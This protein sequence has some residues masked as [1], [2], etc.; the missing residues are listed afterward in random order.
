MHFVSTKVSELE[1]Y[2][3]SCQFRLKKNFYKSGNLAPWVGKK[4]SLILLHFLFFFF[5]NLEPVALHF[6]AWARDQ[7]PDPSSELLQ[8]WKGECFL[9]SH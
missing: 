8:L 6:R 5:F 4:G 7:E 9:L 3:S 1:N 2:Y